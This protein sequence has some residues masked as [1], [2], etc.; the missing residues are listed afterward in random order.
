MIADREHRREQVQVVTGQA[1]DRLATHQVR[2]ESTD[3]TALRN[4]AV[5]A[6]TLHQLRPRASGAR[7]VPTEL[8]RL[9][10]KAVTGQ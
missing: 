10:R 2:D 5:I 9:G 4:V 3:I 7:R 8:S 6:E 1:F